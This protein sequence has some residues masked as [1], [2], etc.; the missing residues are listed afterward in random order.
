MTD[1]SCGA[2][3]YFRRIQPM[4][5]MGKCHGGLPQVFPVTK[6]TPVGIQ[7][8]GETFFPMVP[9]TDFCGHFKERPPARAAALEHI[10]LTKLNVEELEGNA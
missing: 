9:D 2:C 7:L 4:Q 6:Q 5:A 8:F 10:D 3:K 1:E